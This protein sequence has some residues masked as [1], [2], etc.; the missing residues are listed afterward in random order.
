MLTDRHMHVFNVVTSRQFQTEMATVEDYWFY[1]SINHSCSEI[2]LKNI[3]ITSFLKLYLWG[4][5][6]LCLFYLK[7]LSEILNI[8][9]EY[10]VCTPPPL[11][12][13]GTWIWKFW[14]FPGGDSNF[15]VGSIQYTWNHISTHFICF[16]LHFKFFCDVIEHVLFPLNYFVTSLDIC[17]FFVKSS[18]FS[19]WKRVKFT[20]L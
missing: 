19:N 2:L 20:S 18:D 17:Q 4:L 7:G 15:D 1:K 8:I 3:P 10:M 14:F 12:F 5:S 9:H 6:S 16:D 11:I 13:G